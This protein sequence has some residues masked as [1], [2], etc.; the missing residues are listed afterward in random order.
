MTFK[1]GFD[2]NRHELTTAER[3]RGYRSADNRVQNGDG[4]PEPDEVS[5]YAGVTNHKGGA[6]MTR[7]N[8]TD[9]RAFAW[10]AQ[11]KGEKSHG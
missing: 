8:Q 10:S 7:R 3:K 11:R 6:K 5:D 1:K 9:C 4:S 2:P